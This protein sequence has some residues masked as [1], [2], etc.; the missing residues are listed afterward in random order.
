MTWGGTATLY[1]KN[2]TCGHCGS[3]IVSN[4]GY[5]SSKNQCIYICHK[6][7]SPSY[8]YD[9]IQIPGALHTASFQNLD[10]K[11]NDIYNEARNCFSANAFTASVMCCRKLLMHITVDKGAKQNVTFKDYVT[12]LLD[13]NYISIEHK[14]WVDHIREKGNEANHEIV[15]M[16]KSEAEDLLEFCEMLLKTL[17]D[18]PNKMKN[19]KIQYR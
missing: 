13:K 2:Y 6:C 14:D 5:F 11:I 4:L 8:F 16:Q 3:D 1:S 18:Y 10:P 9:K 15:I 12:Y 7:F 17:Y 19:K